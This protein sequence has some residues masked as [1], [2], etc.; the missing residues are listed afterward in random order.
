MRG[1]AMRDSLLLLAIV[2]GE[3]PVELVSTNALANTR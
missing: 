2:A 3:P 1:F